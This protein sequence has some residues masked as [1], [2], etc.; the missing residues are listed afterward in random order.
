[1]KKFIALFTTIVVLIFNV[2][3]SSAQIDSVFWFAAPWVTPSHAGNTPIA[4]RISTFNSPTTVRVY[5]PAGTYDST[6]TVPANT[7]NSHFLTA[8]VNTL[9]SKPADTPLNY[10]IKIEA[11]TLITVVYEVVST[12]NNPETYSL[13]GINGLGTEFVAPF[14]TTWNNGSYAPIQPKSMINIVAT[15]NATTVW[16]TPKTNVVG[17]PASVTYSITLNAGQVYTVENL[18]QATSTAGNN[19]GGTIIVSN[20]PIAVTV[21]DDS[22]WNSAGGGC[23]DL[24]GDQLVPVD[25]I[26]NEYIVNRG[27]MNLA[28]TEGIYIVATQNFTQVTIINASGTTTQLLNQGDTWSYFI[29]DPLSYIQ[30]DKPVYVL[31]ASGFGCELGEAILPPINCAGSSQVSFNRT[32]SQTFILNIL[33]PTTAINDFVLNGS[34]TLV[35][36]SA[37]SLVP[38]TGGF[39]SGAQITFSVADIA[40]GT[41]NL[42]TN[43]SDFFAMG[44]INGGSTTGCYYHYMSS[45]IRR[46]FTDA[47]TDTTLCNGDP[48]VEL[49]GTVSGATT[50][51]VWSVL[52]GTGSFMNPTDLTTQYLPTTS[53]YTQ[54]SLTFVLT[55]TGNC[56]PVSDTLK[57]SFIQA[58]IATAGADNTFCKNNVGAIPINGGVQFASTGIWS[59]GNGGAFGNSNNLSTDYTPS[60]AELA[61]DSVA[62]YLNTAGSFFACPS[63]IDTLVIYFSPAPNVIAGP[64]QTICSSTPIASLNGTI[65]GP[66]TTGIWQT[67]GAGAYSP[68]ES[69]LITDYLIS[70]SDIALGSFYMVLTSTNNLDCLEEKDSLLITIVPEPTI[71]IT[72]QD[73]ICANNLL[74]AFEGTVTNGFGTQWSTGG[75]GTIADPSNLSTTYTVSTLDTVNGFI[76]VYLTTVGVCNSIQDSMRITFVAPPDIDAGIDQQFCQNSTIQLN[77]SITGPN[78]AGLWATLGTGTFNPGN[79]FLQTLYFPSAADVANGGVTLILSANNTFGCASDNDTVFMSF[80][81]IPTA[82]FSLSNVCQEENATFNDLSTTP[83]GSITDWIWDFGDAGTSIAQTPIH[84]YSSSGTFEVELVVLSSNGCSDTIVQAITIHP[85]PVPLFTN[86][87]ACEMNDIFFTDASTISS[88]SIVSWLYDFYSFGSSTDQITQFAFDEPGVYPVSFTVTS[89]LGCVANTVQNVTVISSPTAD[90]SMNPNPALAL[91]EVVFTDQSVGNQIS[92][93][94]WNFGDGEGDNIQN[95]LHGYEL[96]GVYYV[97]LTVTDANNCKDTI[98]KVISVALLPVLPTGFSPNGDGENDVFIIRGG[99]FKTVDFK[100]YNNWGQ[101]IFETNDGNEGWD[102]TFRGESSSLGV[103]TWTFVVEMGNGQIVKKSG[104]VTLIR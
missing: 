67:V 69:N 103:Y 35:P 102:G 75:F 41:A 72:S 17:H 34:A 10:G 73:S 26:G 82:N 8:I 51:G 74:I 1:M 81:E 77:G 40:V 32:N 100:V 48:F 78:P 59:G 96:G 63:D 42:L 20:K 7:L 28:S 13:K 16:I 95:T 36:G 5:Q 101:L 50:T 46:V 25:V 91:Q 104:D 33:C 65:N 6:F 31:Q 52:D 79:A 58:P 93:W 11:D 83:V 85:L 53:D 21:S 97:T 62:L 47:G 64:D 86:T 3:Q 55:S 45:F 84:T 39:W 30:S 24:M 23:R 88:G 4:L 19:L 43:S 94:Y 98:T 90:F 15:E 54:G 89:D 71:A 56:N 87:S 92:D 29:V 61:A 76:D 99:P 2:Q 66:T 37:F 80:I 60:P 38:G 70:G 44:V 68:S 27:N 57:V 49:T 18:S 22:V 12:G 9:E 14:Q